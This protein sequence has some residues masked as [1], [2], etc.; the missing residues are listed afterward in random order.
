MVSLKIL[1]PILAILCSGAPGRAADPKLPPKHAAQKV[2]CVTCH[3]EENPA[4]APR[5]DEACINCHGDLPAMAAYAKSAKDNPHALPKGHT[6]ATF[7]CTECHHQHK[8]AEVKCLKCHSA[9]KMT[10]R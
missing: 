7:A 9:F 1:A 4:K 5:N 3:G 6:P 8:A 10:P 2:G